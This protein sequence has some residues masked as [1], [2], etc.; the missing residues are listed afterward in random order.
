MLLDLREIIGVPGGKVP[1]DFEPDMSDAAFGS[2]VC[3]KQPRAAG[4]VTNRAGMLT[5][6]ANVDAICECVCA[7][8]LKEFDNPVHKLITADLTEGGAGE[9]P[10]GYFLQGDKIDAEEIIETEFIL[11]MDERILCSEDCA[12]LCEDCGSDLN[13]GPCSCKK[14]IDPRLAALGQLLDDE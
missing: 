9:N 1:F 7:R 4:D 11:G 8:C 12:G 2:I 3:V 6:S 13:E 14:K 10:D 5:F